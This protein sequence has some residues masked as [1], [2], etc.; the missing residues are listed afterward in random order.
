[1]NICS[2]DFMNKTKLVSIIF[3]SRSRLDLVKKLL[4]SIEEKTK[5]KSAIEVISIVDQDDTETINFFNSISSTLTYDFYYICRKQKENLD[6]PNDYY[7]LGLKLKSKSY[8]TWIL[9]ND[10]EIKTENWD[11]ILCLGLQQYDRNIYNDIDENN[12]YY[13]IR[14]SDDTHW[15]SNDNINAIDSSCCFPMLSSNYCNDLGEFYPKEIPSWSADTCLNHMIMEAS[16]VLVLD[17]TSILGINHYS[18][19]NKKNEFDEITKRVA[20][21]H[22]KSKVF[23]GH[24]MSD[25]WNTIYNIMKLNRNKYLKF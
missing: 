4:I 8:F 14:I 7:D 3:P 24:R 2:E 15:V 12:L 1:M 5:D 17:F 20:D 9:G 11:E 13:Y 21:A 6:L 22:E 23:I 19:H 18:I 16:N 25:K 10:C